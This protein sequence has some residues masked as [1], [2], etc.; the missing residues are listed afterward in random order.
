[1]NSTINNK[2]TLTMN[3]EFLRRFF[4]IVNSIS[5]S[6]SNNEVIEN[7]HS[8]L[9]FTIQGDDRLRKATFLC[10]I[11]GTIQRWD[12]QVSVRGQSKINHKRTKK[13]QN[14]FIYDTCSNDQAQA[15][16]LLVL[17]YIGVVGSCYVDIWRTFKKFISKSIS[18]M[19]I[20]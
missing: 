5:S 7:L 17:E 8:F 10:E 19:N 4:R 2:Y 9:F 1:M 18:T 6:R 12:R 11:D 13:I 20:N 3:F 14:T 16:D 15:A